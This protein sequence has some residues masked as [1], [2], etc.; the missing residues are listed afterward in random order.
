MLAPTI[1]PI[2]DFRAVLRGTPLED[3]F[4]FWRS[5]RVDG[6]VPPKSRIDPVAMPRHIIPYLFLHERTPDGRFRCRLS[7]TALCAAF[8]VDVTGRHLDEMLPPETLPSRVRL[9]QG[10]IDRETPV[11]FTGNVSEADRNWIKFCRLMMP[12][13]ISG[14]GTDGIFG[15]VIFPEIDLRKLGRLPLQY[16]LPQV[17][18]WASPDDL[19]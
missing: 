1:T 16:S 6:A 12:I 11:V 17:E 15:M 3:C 14:Q 10:V 13:S 9:F 18:A 8:Q 4:E 19:A 5:V 7:G 2:S